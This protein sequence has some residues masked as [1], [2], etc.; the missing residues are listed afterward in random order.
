[1]ERVFGLLKTVRAADINRDGS[2]SE[3]ELSTLDPADAEA[4]R[5]RLA[6]F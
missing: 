6:L 4:W 1:V 3:Q 2:L 5:A